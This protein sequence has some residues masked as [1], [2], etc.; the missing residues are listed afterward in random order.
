MKKVIC[1]VAAFAMVAGVA[2][3]A[4]AEVDLSGDA[5]FRLKWVD[6]G[7]ES[8]SSDKWDSRV[9]LKIHAK[10]E[11]GGYVKARVRML[12]GGWGG[13]AAGEKSSKGLGNVWSD[14]AFVGF[15]TGKFDIAG[16]SMPDDFSPWFADDDRYD[17]FRVLYKDGGLAVA[18][19]YDNEIAAGGFSDDANIYGVTYNQQFSDTMTA[20]VRLSYID[21]DT[22]LF[23][24][25]TDNAFMGSAYVEMSFGGNDILIE[26]SFKEG[27]LHDSDTGY[28]GYAQWS[29]TFGTITPTAIV[30]YTLDGFESHVAFGWLMIGGDVPTT[31][32][33]TIGGGGDTIF[34]GLNTEFQVSED[35]ALQANL[36]W[37]DSDNDNGL[38][39]EMPIELSG[40]MKYNLGK[41]VDWL[42]RAGWLGSDSDV[43]DS[44]AAYTQVQVK[45]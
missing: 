41:G 17:R 30:G 29:A 31:R 28:G 11:G 4:S 36:V 23:Y 12:D 7:L 44:L 24:A 14:Y 8:G 33:E 35:M 19:H 38:Y 40:Q 27:L 25:D 5:R 26:Q 32:V 43:D 34:A 20:A 45:F 2:T 1:A 37:M 22:D 39:G 9:R 21:V 6:T 3:V 15:K 13:L 42:I 16:G 10:T 18:L